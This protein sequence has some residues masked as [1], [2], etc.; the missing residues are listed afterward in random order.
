MQ[1]NKVVKTLVMSDFVIN[2]AFGLTA[3]VFAIFLINNIEGGNAQVAGFATAAYWLV[4]SILQLPIAKFL[5]ETD[6]EKDD[7]YALFIG[8]TLASLSLFLYV[9]ASL[10]WHVYAIESTLGVAMSFAVPAWYGIFTRHI[11]KEKT[12]FE[13]SLESVFSVGL[14]T[15]GAS[16]LGGYLADNFGFQFLF[17]GSGILALIGALSIILV[18]PHLTKISGTGQTFEAEIERDKKTIID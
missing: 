9:F 17:I 5:D 15:A 13:W 1:I 18:Y 2:S 12:S 3:P 10:P 7:F 11:D 4:K 6:G 14:A 8:Q 16:A